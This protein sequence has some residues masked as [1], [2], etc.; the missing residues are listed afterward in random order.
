MKITASSK[1]SEI[2]L[3]SLFSYIPNI[4]DSRRRVIFEREKNLEP[5]TKDKAVVDYF[6]I[7]LLLHSLFI[8]N[9]VRI[10]AYLETQFYADYLSLLGR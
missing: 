10:R 5:N 8:T 4:T 3:S 1:M 9:V 2:F 7:I 6:I